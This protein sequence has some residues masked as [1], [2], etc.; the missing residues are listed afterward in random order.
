MATATST[1][2][3]Q[4]REFAERFGVTIRT[5]HHYDHLGLLKPTV[6]SES[7]YRL[8]S[9]ADVPRLQQIVT[10]KF[11]G[12]SLKQIGELLDGEVLELPAML[13]MQREIMEEKRRQLD[14]AMQAIDSAERIILSKSEP[15]RDVFIRII[16]VIT[17]EQ[18]FQ[19]KE[20]LK[21]YYTEEQL[22]DFEA[23][24]RENPGEAA[25][26]TMD[27]TTLI[28]DVERAIA[29]GVDPASQEGQGLAARWSGLIA[30]FTRGNAGVATSLDALHADSRN[31]P[32]TF[33]KPYSDEVEEFI[34]K[35]GFGRA[36][37][38]AAA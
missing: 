33:K 25:R 27:W 34:R 10:L 31:W 23:R 2:L 21:K 22:A 13:R 30:S 1:V 18:N 12:F 6:Y 28:G 9:D 14:R 4:V 38:G 7:G 3:Y 35:A 24:A 32:A 37:D 29:D 15:D 8:Y 5:L 11:L 20:W 16:E 26:G 36:S 19:D 17:M